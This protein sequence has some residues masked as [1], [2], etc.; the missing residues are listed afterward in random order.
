MQV[1]LD[2]AKLNEF[3]GRVVGELGVAFSVALV[4]IGDELGLY[5]ALSGA[6]P[7][8]SSELAQRTGTEERLVREW[9]ANQAAGE[10]VEYD[11]A[12][13]RFT[14]PDE[15]AIV[16]GDQAGPVDLP[17]AFQIAASL[18]A[19]RPKVV[20]AFRT[21]IGLD[22]GKHDDQLLWGTDRFFGAAYRASLVGS[23]IP[24]LDGV[25]SKLQAGAHVADVGCGFGAATITMAEAYPAS[26]FAGYDAHQRSIEV[27]RKKAADAGVAD[28]VTFEV[29]RATDFP[30]SGFDL[31]AVLDA[32]H[33]MGDPVA[34]SAHILR[35]LDVEGTLVLVEPFAGDRLE[36]NLNPVGRL[37][38]AGSTMICVPG[39]LAQE[40]AAAL[41]NQAGEKRLRE[42]VTAAGFTRFR[43][44]AAT[45]FN[46]ILEARP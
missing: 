22:W 30:G 45:P 13:E 7:L 38:Y 40:G 31:V 10:Y 39:S 18:L 19:D 4:L 20:E 9:L 33:D 6:G 12:T 8:T 26:T 5:R 34:A 1:A 15:H 29:A 41:G 43:R 16:L 42:V 23:W 24:A 11:A 46:L 36:E 27:A 28:R 37:F 25:E 2:E 21:G 3:L 17:G 32:L 44:A 35:S 14:L